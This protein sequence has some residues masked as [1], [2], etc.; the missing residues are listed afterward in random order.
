MHKAVGRTQRARQW[1][2]DGTDEPRPCSARAS[3]RA[4]PRCHQGRRRSQ[5][6]WGCSISARAAP[7][8]AINQREERA[9]GA[10]ADGDGRVNARLVLPAPCCHVATRE[11]FQGSKGHYRTENCTKQE[12][13][14]EDKRPTKAQVPR[15]PTLHVYTNS[16]APRIRPSVTHPSELES[17]RTQAH[18]TFCHRGLFCSVLEFGPVPTSPTPLDLTQVDYFPMIRSPRRARADE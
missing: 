9:L 14:P 12:A 15:S 7:Q 1:Q 18:A 5:S 10:R 13:P 6:S 8:Q 3:H 17:S 4:R 16:P 11:L 2:S